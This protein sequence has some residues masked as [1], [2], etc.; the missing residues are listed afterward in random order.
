MSN[1][2]FTQLITAE[3]RAATAL[4]EWRNSAALTRA[5]FCIGAKRLGLLPEQDAVAAAKGE[6]P[7]S[8]AD[9]LAALPVEIDATEAQITWAAT[10][11]VARMDPILLAV[12]ASKGIAYTQLDAMFGWAG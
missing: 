1:I 4:T 2:D 5:Q 12:A 10:A 8:F 3:E 11:T 9:A 7:Q 6:W